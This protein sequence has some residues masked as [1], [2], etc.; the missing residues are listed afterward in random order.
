MDIGAVALTARMTDGTERQVTITA[1]RG[2]TD[3]PMTNAQIEDKLRAL[4]AYRGVTW[5][6]QPLIDAV[7]SLDTLPDAARLAA[8]ACRAPTTEVAA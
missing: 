2:S 5:D 3:N 4:A 6:T 1:A 7:W 8:L